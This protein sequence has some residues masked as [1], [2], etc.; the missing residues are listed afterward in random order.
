[1]DRV[2]VVR[3]V[4]T[5]PVPITIYT[6]PGCPFSAILRGRLRVSRVPYALVNIWDDPAA[7]EFVREHADGD[8]TVPTV[9]IDGVVLVNPAPS[10]VVRRAR[11]AGR[12]R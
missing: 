7:A 11:D 3:A 12:G 1:M 5:G 4:F 10:E 2:G 8:E 9:E 6:R